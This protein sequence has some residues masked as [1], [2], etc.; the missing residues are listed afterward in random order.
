[1]ALDPT[2]VTASSNGNGLKIRM[3]MNNVGM[4]AEARMHA[5]LEVA[6]EWDASTA[7][8]TARYGAQ[9][10]YDARKANGTL[11]GEL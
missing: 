7:G 1:M 3:I 2:A 11:Y 10:E 5:V 8:S 6:K 9:R 4:S